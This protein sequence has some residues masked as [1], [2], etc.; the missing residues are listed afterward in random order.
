VSKINHRCGVDEA[1]RGPLAGAV[2]AA[3]VILNPMRPIKG[4]ADS[5]TL[6]EKR[7]DLLALEIREHALSFSIAF[8]SVE[9]I[10]AINILQ[11][12]LL[13]MK[14]AVEGLAHAPS[15]VLVD[16]LHVPK[17]SFKSRA[18]VEGDRLIE[19]ISAASIL[20]KTARD[21]EM[22]ALHIQFPQYNFRQHKG[23]GTAEHMRAL[24]LHGPCALHRQS[25][26][27]VRAAYAQAAFEFA[28]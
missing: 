11:A 12:T 5:K 7:R 18:I 27:P 23:Y 3:A 19:E 4:L 14:R 25:F 20:A 17:I 21:A 24:K 1:G 8:A 2:F 13:A 28:K 6:S 10:D 26:A 22:C 9:E 15:E 16:G